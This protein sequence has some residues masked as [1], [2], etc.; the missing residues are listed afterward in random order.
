MSLV[1]LFFILTKI[2]A[3]AFIRVWFFVVTALAIGISLNAFF[4]LFNLWFASFIALIIALPFA[5]V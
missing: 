5:F 4:S 1:F 3:E 2:R